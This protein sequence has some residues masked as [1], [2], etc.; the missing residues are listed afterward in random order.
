MSPEERKQRAKEAYLDLR[1]THPWLHW[2]YYT[3]RRLKKQGVP[4]SQLPEPERLE[5]WATM[6]PE[7]EVCGTAFSR[8]GKPGPNGT[9]RVVKASKG[10]DGVYELTMVHASCAGGILGRPRKY[11]R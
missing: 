7:C 8:T 10:K 4:E 1:A 9:S 3:R 2:S 11:T 6:T 5:L